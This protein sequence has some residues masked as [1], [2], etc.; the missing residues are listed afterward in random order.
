[1][2]DIGRIFPNVMPLRLVT[3]SDRGIGQSNETLDGLDRI[4]AAHRVA[5]YP[6]VVAAANTIEG[7]LADWRNAANYLVV[8]VGFIILGIAGFAWLFI[9]LFQNHQAFARIR[10]E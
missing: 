3:E 6:L 5:N 9:R 8:V 1:D 7:A 10:A 2:S 4:V